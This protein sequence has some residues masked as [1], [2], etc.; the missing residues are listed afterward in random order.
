MKANINYGELLVM[1]VIILL[2]LIGTV[3]DITPIML[4]IQYGTP[5]LLAFILVMTAIIASKHDKLLEWQ[6]TGKG[7]TPLDFNCSIRPVK[8]PLFYRLVHVFYLLIVILIALHGYFGSAFL[9]LIM[10]GAVK[11]SHEIHKAMYGMVTKKKTD[12]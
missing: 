10:W 3:F 8:D 4:G 9:W 6:K 12:N 11:V 5:F 1:G 2:V 7:G